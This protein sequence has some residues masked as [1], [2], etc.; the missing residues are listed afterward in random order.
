MRRILLT[1][2]TG[3]ETAREEFRSAT[4]LLRVVND[5]KCASLVWRFANY[6]GRRPQGLRVRMDV[7]PT[8]LV[9]QL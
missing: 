7:L 2:V 5:G 9:Q 4:L 3:H 6:D 8:H 1:L